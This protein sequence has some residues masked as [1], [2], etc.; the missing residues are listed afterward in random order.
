MHPYRL[1]CIQERLLPP[2]TVPSQESFV[3]SAGERADLLHKVATMGRLTHLAHDCPKKHRSA[4]V[5]QAARRIVKEAGLH[6]D[7]DLGRLQQIYPFLFHPCL[8][9]AVPHNPPAAHAALF[10]TYC[11]S[12]CPGIIPKPGMHKALG[13]TSS[14]PRF[15][16][17]SWR[18]TTS[19]GVLPQAN[20]RSI[21]CS[22][23][24]PTTSHGA[25]WGHV[26]PS[27]DFGPPA[28]QEICRPCEGG[29]RG[30]QREGL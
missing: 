27:R 17:C 2:C 7:C 21:F 28:P 10:S 26:L 1:S 5:L 9:Q 8:C 3:A 29:A 12:T 30:A 18:S 20:M 22:R 24:R 15:T 14:S 16:A 13:E 25:G 23:L 6:L 4:E 11:Q 19:S